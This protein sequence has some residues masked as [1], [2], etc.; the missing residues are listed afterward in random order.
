MKPRHDFIDHTSELALRL[1]AD[2]WAALLTEAVRAIAA[3]LVREGG[4]AGA[5]RAR[6]IALEAS[7]REALLV[8]L[9]NELIFLAETERWAPADVTPVEASEKVVRLDCPGVALAGPPSRI[10]AAT[11][12]G[13][14]VR[15]AGAGVAAEVILDV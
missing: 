10:K 13:L 4:H 6:T 12:H 7:D 11:F 5:A 8:D 14:S 9:V 3:E 2:D 15:T 1:E